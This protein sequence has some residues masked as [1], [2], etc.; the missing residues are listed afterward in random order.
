[1]NVAVKGSLQASDE[2]GAVMLSNVEAL[3]PMLRDNAA[4]AREER[5]VP[6]EN[7]QAHPG[8]RFFSGASA[9]RVGRC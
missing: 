8:C 9:D 5:R 4:R 6:V 7:V 2:S 1:M 3:Q